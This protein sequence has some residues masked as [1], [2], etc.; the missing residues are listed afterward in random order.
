[1]IGIYKAL[2]ELQELGWIDGGKMPRLVAVQSEGCAPIV[3]AWEEGNSHAEPWENAS[4]V[5]FGINVAKALGDFLILD[6]VRKTDGCAIA[7]DDET[8]LEE[9]KA[10]AS[11]E[12]AF[13]CPEGAAAFAAVRQLRKNSWIREGE[14]VVVLNTG[15]GIKYPNTV[16]VDAPVLQA[17]EKLTK[18]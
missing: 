1:M 6:A 15:A 2:R 14:R 7:I 3:K 16:S 11:A 5:A 8:I 4:T 12:G 9:L 10:V 13:V 17:G 18:K